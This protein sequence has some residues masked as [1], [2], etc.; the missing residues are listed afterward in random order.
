MT[1]NGHIFRA[2][3]NAT[4]HTARTTDCIY[5]SGKTNLSDT[6]LVI[7]ILKPR[8]IINLKFIRNNK[9]VFGCQCAFIHV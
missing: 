8:S 4:N 7:N 5:T 3:T 6:V 9:G 1:N 2:N